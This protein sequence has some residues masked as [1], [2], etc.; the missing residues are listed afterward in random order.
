MVSLC[1]GCCVPEGRWRRQ[2][3]KQ[4]YRSTVWTCLHPEKRTVSA[5]DAKADLQRQGLRRG[6]FRIPLRVRVL[7]RLVP[8]Q[9]QQSRRR[10]PAL[11]RAGST[12]RHAVKMPLP[13]TKAPRRQLCT[14]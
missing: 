3:L 1:Q 10:R 6:L 11:Q 2:L 9:L 7:R 12:L 5:D 8:M 4:R 13:S 14:D